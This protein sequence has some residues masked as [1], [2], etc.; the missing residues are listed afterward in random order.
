MEKLQALTPLVEQISIDEAFL[1]VTDKPGKAE[2]TGRALQREILAE[3]ALPCSLGIASNKLV[4]KIA[5][6]VGKAAGK[7][8]N[9]F[10]PPNAITIV[11]VSHEAEFLAPLPVEALWGV[12]PKT[13][14]RLA[15]IGVLTIGDLA[16]FPERD[17]VRLFGKNGNDLA[18]HAK[19]IDESPIVSWHEIK[20]ISQETTFA[21]DVHDEKLLKQTILTLSEQ[22]G[23]RLRRENLTSTTVKLKLRWPDFTTLTRQRTYPSPVEQDSQIYQAALA[24]FD[25]VWETSQAVRL[26][27]VGVSGLGPPVRQLSLWEIAAD[28]VSA[29]GSAKEQRLQNAIDE[30]RSRFGKGMLTR[31]G[32]P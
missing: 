7:V 5:N 2:E 14:A 30:I 8:A 24:L 26:I 22:V 6:D 9:Y 23:S 32:K 3:L 31:G 16:K 20:S 1:D 21:Q 15:E 17:L 18:R 29:A 19:G 10:G 25:K 13:A 27:G 28:P 11:P 12:G 4:A